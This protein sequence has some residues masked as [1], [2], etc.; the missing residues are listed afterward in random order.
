MNPEQQST[1]GRPKIKN[2]TAE[3]T[4]AMRK[5][6]LHHVKVPRER[7]RRDSDEQ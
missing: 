5:V 7:A 6:N 2:Y 3:E 4:K 1:S